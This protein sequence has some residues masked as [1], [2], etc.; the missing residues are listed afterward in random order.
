MPG[1]APWANEQVA[2]YGRNAFAGQ[3]A[4]DE[5]RD[6]EFAILARVVNVAIVHAAMTSSGRASSM[7]RL[8]ARNNRF[9][10]VPSGMP[11]AA[12]TA[13]YERSSR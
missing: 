3:G 5:V 4:V 6:I 10:T 11:S 8:R 1:A 9:L 12:A 2:L 13:S 7:S